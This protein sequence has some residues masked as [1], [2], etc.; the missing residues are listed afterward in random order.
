MKITIVDKE[1]ENAE[2]EV[3]IKCSALNDDI[4]ELIN[5]FKTGGEH[6]MTFYK[7][8]QIV[9]VN[10][11]DIYYWESVDDKTFAYTKDKVYETKKRIYQLEME[12]PKS[13]YFR[14]SKSVIV[15]LNKIDSLTPAFS[16]RFEAVLKNGYKIIISRMYVANLKEILGI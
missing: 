16:G 6:K 11:E 3:I 10:P 7:E 1:D 4:I 2:D 13:K 12:L 15:N 9:L 14:A 5:M 8:S